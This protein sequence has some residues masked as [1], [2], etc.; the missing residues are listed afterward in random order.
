MI[1]RYRF[2][3]KKYKFIYANQNLKKNL[4]DMLKIALIF[5][6]FNRLDLTNNSFNSIYKTLM[7][8]KK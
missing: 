5:Y 8:K 6:C 7:Y 1:I 2:F 4:F 3:L